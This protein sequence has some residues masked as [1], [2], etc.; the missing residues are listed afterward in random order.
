VDAMK[1]SK[2]RSGAN[3][4]KPIVTGTKITSQVTAIRP[5]FLDYF[6]EENLKAILRMRT[7]FLT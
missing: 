2:K 5:R 6:R 7:Q 1:I 4:S 3:T